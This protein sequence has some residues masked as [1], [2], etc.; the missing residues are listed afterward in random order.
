MEDILYKIAITQIPKVGAVTAKNLVSYCGGV[1][2]V[3]QTS[4]RELMRVPG[5][6]ERIADNI[7]RGDYLERAEQE[8]NFIEKNDIQPIFYLDA[9]YPERLR[10]YNDSPIMLYCRGDLD[11]NAKRTV[12]IVGTRMPSPQGVAICEELVERLKPYGAT[13][14]SGLAYG[15]DIAAHRK[16]V[17][18]GIS[19]IGILGHGLQTIYPPSHRSIAERMM[20]NGGVITEFPSDTKPD[21]ENFPMR[22]RIIAGLCDAIIVVE[23]AKK[24]GS[25][26]TAHMANEYNKDVFAV[27]GRLKD[28][29]SLG[30]NHLIK[31][32]KALLLES[33]AD[34]AYI[35]RWEELD[36][37]KEIQQQLF[38]ELSDAEK[39]I[40]N[41]LNQSEEASIDKLLVETKIV[42]SELA[43]LLLNLEFKGVVK[44][45]PGKR[46]T[47][48]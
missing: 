29:N 23:T 25:M 13:I 27:P 3:F 40:V 7:L 31:T 43:S 47:L 21:R 9:A 44:S 11:L 28:K 16:S 10:H 18:Q 14:I 36:Q 33:A 26:I 37:Q 17:E 30:C 35:L 6:G 4:R 20:V 41:L 45:L 32:H 38:V 24:G 19:T 15:I 39:I 2:A 8:L 12:G 34:I 46:Y 1:A 42:G 22:N 48:I 5:V